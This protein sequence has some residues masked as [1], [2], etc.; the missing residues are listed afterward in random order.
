MT[1]LLLIG[2][3]VSLSLWQRVRGSISFFK[4]FAE[5]LYHMVLNLDENYE[6]RMIRLRSEKYNT[7]MII[8]SAVS[9]KDV[10]KIYIASNTVKGFADGELNYF[11]YPHVVK[12]I[13][14]GKP[15]TYRQGDYLILSQCTKEEID[16]FKKI[17][18]ETPICLLEY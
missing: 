14:K 15:V 16:Q 5:D 10:N 4:P 9:N 2:F 12:K 7:I 1:V 13:V 8:K 11:F 6:E 3:L 18:I 17:L